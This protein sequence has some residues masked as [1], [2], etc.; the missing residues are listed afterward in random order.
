MGLNGKRRFY[1]LIALSIAFTM[2]ISLIVD[3]NS[4]GKGLMQVSQRTMQDL[5][6]K[7]HQCNE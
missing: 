7:I 5:Q 2:S 4:P 3:L 1:G 6:A